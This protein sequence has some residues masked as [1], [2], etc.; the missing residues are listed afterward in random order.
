MNRNKWDHR[1]S[2]RG[3]N[4]LE[5]E[6]KEEGVAGGGVSERCEY[7]R[8]EEA[9]RVFTST[10]GCTSLSAKLRGVGTQNPDSL[11]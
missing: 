4:E 5:K 3:A 6:V 10:H 1:F 7:D 2:G 9:P 11:L 8:K